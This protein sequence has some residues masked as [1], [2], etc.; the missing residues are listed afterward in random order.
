VLAHEFLQIDLAGFG[1]G[2]Q[3]AGQGRFTLEEQDQGLPGLD[4]RQLRPEGL[5]HIEA[6]G[7]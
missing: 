5:I 7:Q 1:K 6:R 3:E 2:E 4:V